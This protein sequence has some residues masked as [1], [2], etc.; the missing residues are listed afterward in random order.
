MSKPKLKSQ[1]FIFLIFTVSFLIF[2]PSQTQA[3]KKFVKKTTGTSA[4]RR[5]SSGTIP[6]VVRY[7]GDRLAILLSFLNFNGIESVSYSFTYETNGVPQGA[8]GTITAGNNPTSIRELAFGTASGGVYRYHYNLKNARL[9]LTARF[10]NA[11]T[12]TKAYRIKTYQ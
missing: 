6:A 10:T 3:A 9:V 8:G 7:R 5:T 2:V 11:S 4:A 12:R 1:I